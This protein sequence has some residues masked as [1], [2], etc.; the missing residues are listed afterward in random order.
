MTTKSSIPL[1][2]LGFAGLVASIYS[3]TIV[4]W[5]TIAE[6]YHTPLTILIPF[7][8]LLTGIGNI[9]FAAV[10]GNWFNARSN[11]PK[12]SLGFAIA[13]FII[14]VLSLTGEII[15]FGTGGQFGFIA[16]FSVLSML[17][18]LW[19]AIKS[20]QSIT[21]KELSSLGATPSYVPSLSNLSSSKQI[22]TPYE[23][24]PP[25]LS[26][27][28]I[29][30]QTEIE[31]IHSGIA[32]LQFEMNLPAHVDK[33][34]L[35]KQ[36]IQQYEDRLNVILR[37]CRQDE[38]AEEPNYLHNKCVIAL[39]MATSTKEEINNKCRCF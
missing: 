1:V 13:F 18:A 6:F 8:F 26:A 25:K 3:L 9:L 37:E 27:K 28:A 15:K 21:T 31:S 32:Q 11:H 38:P 24:P 14:S 33:P 10:V 35:Q 5:P 36:Y 22:I 12:K 16:A 7:G 20:Y 30:W 4:S 34:E 17:S 19:T 2:F 39:N 29:E 23:K